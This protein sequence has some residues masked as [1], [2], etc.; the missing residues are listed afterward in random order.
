VQPAGEVHDDRNEGA[1]TATIYYVGISSFAGPFVVPQP[2]PPCST[3]DWGRWTGSQRLGPTPPPDRVHLL[4][5]GRLVGG[6]PLLVVVV[7]VPLRRS[8]REHPCASFSPVGPRQRRSPPGAPLDQPL[9]PRL[10]L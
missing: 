2:L 8:T 3:R 9:P 5:A 4:S 7:V 1:Q 10:P 6:R